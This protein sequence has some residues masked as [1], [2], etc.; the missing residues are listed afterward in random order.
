MLK[1]FNS[2]LNADVLHT[3]IP[4]DTAINHY[5]GCKLSDHQ[6]ALAKPLWQDLAYRQFTRCSCS[7]G[8]EFRRTHGGRG[9]TR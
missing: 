1:S 3:L 8:A 9:L 7:A 6:Q 5:I 2:A 4:W